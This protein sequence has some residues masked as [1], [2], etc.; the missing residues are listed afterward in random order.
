MSDEKTKVGMYDP[1]THERRDTD[2]AELDLG[3]RCRAVTTIIKERERQEELKAQ[4]KFPWSCGDTVTLN[5][6]GL[7]RSIIPS[8]KLAVLAEE[9]GEVSREVCEG[10][11]KQRPVNEDR[12][13]AELTQVAA[14]CL[15]WLESLDNG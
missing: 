8:E 13:R 15:A 10:L 3:A 6:I 14:V 7:L 11:A 12:L 5:E 4:G 2:P 1:E 9:F